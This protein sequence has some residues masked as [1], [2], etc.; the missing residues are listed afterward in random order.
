MDNP[1]DLGVSRVPGDIN[2]SAADERDLLAADIRPAPTIDWDA[3][4]LPPDT[5]DSIETDR[6]AT[7]RLHAE[8]D[9]V[10][11]FGEYDLL[12]EVARG[13]M[14]VVYKALDRRLNRVVA[15]KM[16]LS[17]RFASEQELQRF[18][19]EAE[20]AA[21]LDHPGIVPI[22]EIAELEG[23]HYFT[24]K[25]VPGG[26]MAEHL[27]ELRCEP[28]R[29]AALL[30]K[31]ARAVSHAHQRGILHRD[32]KPA[33][34]LIDEAGDPLVTDL[35]LAKSVAADSGLTQSGGI[36][37]T[38]S[39]MSPEQA[40][41]GGDV[42]T[43]ADVYALGAI[44]YE[45][46]SGRP[47]HQA[48]TTLDTLLKVINDTPAPLRSLDSRI[49]IGLELIASKCLQRSPTDRYTSAAALA[50]DLERWLAGDPLSVRSPS[51]ASAV[52]LWLRRNLRSAAGAAIVGLVAGLVCG[53]T[54][55]FCT[56]NPQL[57]SASQVYNVFPNEPR[58]WGTFGFDVP[59]WVRDALFLWLIALLQFVG[60]AN[61]AL[62]R[63]AQRAGRIASGIICGF[64]LAL[65]SYAVSFGWGPIVLKSVYPAYGDVQLL[66][67]AMFVDST[68][69][70]ERLRRAMLRRHPD[71]ARAVPDARA[72]F[73]SAKIALDQI[74]SVPGG[75]WLGITVA[76][77]AGMV[78]AFCGTI[79]AGWLLEREGKLSRVAGP[80]L[81]I[82]GAATSFC[83]IGVAYWTGAMT[84]LEMSVPP[85]A[86]QSPF[87]A[88]LALAGYGALRRWRLG[89]RLLLHATWLI[90]M[91]ATIGFFVRQSRTG[92]VV[93]DLVARGEFERAAERLES[94][95]N[96]QPRD[97][98]GHFGAG[99]LRLRLGQFDRY[100]ARCQT[101][102]NKFQATHSP[103]DA[104]KTAKLCLLAP[105]ALADLQP[106]IELA[107]LA[108]D[109]GFQTQY[110]PWF[111]LLRGLAEFRAGRAHEAIGWLK[112]CESNPHPIRVPTAQLIESMALITLGQMEEAQ[113]VLHDATT[114]FDSYLSSADSTQ[115][116]DNW[117]DRV[118][119][120]QLRDEANRRF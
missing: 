101:M 3:K 51:A 86:L 72:N 12:S 96:Y 29:V 46:L 78:P 64:A 45:A 117:P 90:A 116:N 105:G 98:Y 28:R 1:S 42:T 10:R 115:V 62:S 16:V 54:L 26:S 40:S 32:L 73:L 27:A 31:V 120:E 5:N 47:P 33:N 57:A 113:S 94:F 108:F 25:F 37:G 58:P 66:S 67:R 35:G 79:L 111:Y 92:V 30:A 95:L 39:Y 85:A 23:R 76:L 71:L 77:L 24:M 43:A 59:G 88:G 118:I 84:W 106:A 82:M 44:L 107:E 60:L 61:V 13:G 93:G 50:D 20:A 65:S 49:D 100:E 19:I 91:L 7:E 34:I 63:P 52:H 68:A 17:G 69:D 114:A 8:A 18:H 74:G 56:I 6:S 11:R 103:A 38:P 70:A 15:L 109:E 55:W 48:A 110:E 80:Y 99:L 97:A 36:V 81:E 9:A 14:G 102:L 4:T 21:R 83:V 75:M 41:G 112:K 89:I 2:A 22:Y 119:F 87:F 104:D 53:A